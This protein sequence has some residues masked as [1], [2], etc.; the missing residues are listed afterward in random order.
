V[1]PEVEVAGAK[2]SLWADV[3][4][5]S[6]LAGGL[7]LMAISVSI[8]GLIDPNPRIMGL[9]SV[10]LAWYVLLLVLL[11]VGMALNVVLSS[12]ESALTLSGV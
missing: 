1:A 5:G 7:L 4:R 8:G 12:C 6:L 2:G 10:G 11:D 9:S 3:G